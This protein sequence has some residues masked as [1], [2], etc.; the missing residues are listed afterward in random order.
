MI[1]SDHDYRS[2]LLIW[3]VLLLT[4]ALYPLLGGSGIR[5]WALLLSVA[6]L[7]IVVLKPDLIKHVYALWMNVGEAIGKIISILVL[8]GIFFLLFTPIALLRCLI[9]KD[10]LHKKLDR[11]VSS[12]W[13]A[14]TKQPGSLKYQF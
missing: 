9:R 6:C 10:P 8:L 1:Y 12:Y 11:D 13:I 7:L 2:F 3:A 14:R 5:I 4:V